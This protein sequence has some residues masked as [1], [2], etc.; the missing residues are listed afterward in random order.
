MFCHNC[1]KIYE[2]VDIFVRD[3]GGIFTFDKDRCCFDL[4]CQR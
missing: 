4:V 3:N 1:F 2:A